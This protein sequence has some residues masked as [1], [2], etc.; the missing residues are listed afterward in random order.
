M[1]KIGQREE[2]LRNINQWEPSLAIEVL[3]RLSY[4][5]LQMIEVDLC[6]HPAY[7]GGSKRQDAK[8]AF[9]DVFGCGCS[10]GSELGPWHK[11]DCPRHTPF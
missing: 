8:K 5:T 4:N 9:Q 6:E 10:S 1:G 7:V 11:K 2:M 3:E